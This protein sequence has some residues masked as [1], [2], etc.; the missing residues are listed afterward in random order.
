M[1]AVV[2]QF[3]PHWLAERKRS[4]AHRFDEVSDGIL[5]IPPV[6]TTAQQALDAALAIYLHCEWAKPRGNRANHGVNLTTPADEDAWTNLGVPEVW[7]F[8]RDTKVP[9]VHVLGAG[10]VYQPRAVDADGWLRSPAA[11]VEFCQMRPGK[12]WLRIDGDE[13]TAGE[14]KRSHIPF[15]SRRT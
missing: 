9:E 3:P 1:K 14:L 8:H 4:G 6:Q 5:H 13:A 15:A 7:V 10:T 12:V 11:G 2:A